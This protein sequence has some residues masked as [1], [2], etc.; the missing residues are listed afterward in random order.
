MSESN[1]TIVA[2]QSKTTE[3][4]AVYESAE[5]AGSQD[6]T[7]MYVSLAAF[8][9]SE[10]EDFIEVTIGEEGPVS[11]E[12]GKDTKSFG[13]YESESGAISGMYVSHEVLAS[14]ET[15][16][17][18]VAPESRATSISPASE[19]DF[20]ESQEDEALEAEADSL[21]SGADSGETV[22]T[23]EEAQEDET[24]PEEEEA[25]DLLAE[26]EDAA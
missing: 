10:P 8:G 19:E 16:D 13:V 12:K 26:A 7:G 14:E 6:L 25:A 3:N 20:E 24:T 5:V 22:E 9:E 23:T 15:E 4:Y 21:L 18:F 1:T 11:L 17:G 2:E